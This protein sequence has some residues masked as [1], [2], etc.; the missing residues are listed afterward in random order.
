[1]STVS[2]VGTV[3]RRITRGRIDR[4]AL[5]G[6]DL[7]RLRRALDI[8]DYEVAFAMG[9][10]YYRQDQLEKSPRVL[11]E[12]ATRYL[13]AIAQVW[14]ERIEMSPE[15]LAE[16][17]AQAQADLVE[18]NRQR[19]AERSREKERTVER[20][21]EHDAE[22]EWRERR[23]EFMARLQAE[24]GKPEPVFCDYCLEP[25]AAPI[26]EAELSHAYDLLVRAVTW[27]N[28][29]TGGT[30]RP[31]TEFKDLQAELVR[32]GWARQASY[33]QVVRKGQYVIEPVYA[34]MVQL[35]AEAQ[36]MLEH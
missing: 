4:W 9:H 21:Q 22:R 33:R 20:R 8:K 32:R 12:T 15:E 6:G 27:T 13:S 3:A 35:N 17:D 5:S 31:W 30:R 7:R 24:W 16:R 34:Y 1:L 18:Y 2:T 26:P 28:P 25:S 36:A 14:R 29:K 23:K 10:G 19:E 11:K